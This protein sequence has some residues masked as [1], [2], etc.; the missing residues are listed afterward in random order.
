MPE[1]KEPVM[2][3][4]QLDN[5]SMKPVVRDDCDKTMVSIRLHNGQKI[6]LEL[7]TDHTVEDVM[8]YVL[9]IAPVS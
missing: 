2:P 4:V 7:N 8:K 9:S 6:N 5:E 3:E 1:V